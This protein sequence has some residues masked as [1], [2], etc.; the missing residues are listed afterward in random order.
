MNL[1][2]CYDFVQALS[3]YNFFYQ[4]TEPLKSK[5]KSILSCRNK[6]LAIMSC[7]NVL[8]LSCTCRLKLWPLTS[9][10]D[11]STRHQRA[12]DLALQ[13]KNN[14]VIQRWDIKIF[15]NV[16]KKGGWLISFSGINGFL[17][18]NM[19]SHLRA[20]RPRCALWLSYHEK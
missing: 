6:I 17:A 9:L 1:K 7:G 4:T 16:C 11:T 3:C 2:L 10:T 8:L 15:V 13:I 18:R 20:A 5:N 14:L 12:Y 19:Q